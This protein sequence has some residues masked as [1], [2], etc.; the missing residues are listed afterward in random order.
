MRAEKQA[1]EGRR[2]DQSW[3]IS[4]HAQ[5]TLSHQTIAP[6]MTEAIGTVPNVGLLPQEVAKKDVYC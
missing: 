3:H 2:V 1:K 4:K 6:T 5:L